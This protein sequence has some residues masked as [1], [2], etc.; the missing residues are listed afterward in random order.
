MAIDLVLLDGEAAQGNMEW[1]VGK[2]H[3]VQSKVGSVA[4]VAGALAAGQQ[5]EAVLFWHAAFGP[6]APTAVTRLLQHPADVWHAGLGVGMGGQP[7]LIDFVAP[8]WML[9]RDPAA[10]IEATSWRLSL[11]ACLIRTEVL[12]QMG[13]PDPRFRTLEAAAL[14][15]GHRYITRGVIPRSQPD[16]L[17]GDSG[18]PAVELP[19]EDE[20]R[21]VYYR[22]GRTWSFWALARA[23][24]T[25]YVA[26]ITAFRAARRVFGA[27]RPVEPRPFVRAASEV[28]PDIAASRVSV[29][30]PTLD[31]YPYLRTV[32]QQ[33]GEQTVRPLEVIVVDQTTPAERQASIAAEFPNLPLV[34]LHLDQPGQCTSRNRGL[35]HARGDYLL[36]LDD[37]DEIAPDLIERHLRHL[38]RMQVPVSCGVAHEVG[39]G[40]LPIAFTFPRVSDVCPTNNTMI[41]MSVLDAS[42]LFDLAYDRGQRADADLG[43]RIYLSGACL[44]LDPAIAVLHHH[45]PRGGL[46]AHKAR[47]VTYASSRQRLAHRHLPSVSESYLARRY[48]APRQVKEMLWQRV[49][50]TLAMRGPIWRK[51]AKMILGLLWMPT[52]LWQIRRRAA[53]AAAMFKTYPRIPKL[54]EVAIPLRDRSNEVSMPASK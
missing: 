7:G 24:L 28:R 44:M 15:L 50:G 30:I 17:V 3:A 51:A 19:F 33:L 34:V 1:P 11:R 45:A 31:R 48:F 39:A 8:T 27:S 32:L 14:E 21:F 47:V 38:D 52:T 29:L 6:P 2:V 40:P 26:P 18:T 35:Q 4:G 49:T 20:L 46:R 43:M 36:F 53:Q 41:R 37:D 10:D 12:R 42:G 16:L 54:A 5:C 9:N 22:F 23:L 25:G 13:G